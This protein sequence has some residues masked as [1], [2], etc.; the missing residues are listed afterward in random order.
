MSCAGAE[1]KT[2]S[3]QEPYLLAQ[4]AVVID[5]ENVDVHGGGVLRSTICGD[6][7]YAVFVFGF[8]VQR[9]FQDDPPL[10]VSQLDGKQAEWISI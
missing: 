1:E 8:P 10:L 7:P 3:T 6:Y 9:A 5:V 4:R 2:D